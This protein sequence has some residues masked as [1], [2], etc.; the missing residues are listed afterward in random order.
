MRIVGDVE[1]WG[2][3]VFTE[4][5]NIMCYSGKMHVGVELEAVP[6]L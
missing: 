1:N 3:P 2:L 5:G 6:D 4:G